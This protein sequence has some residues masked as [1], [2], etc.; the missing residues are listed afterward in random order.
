M[1]LCHQGIIP[2]SC[3]NH[4]KESHEEIQCG[5]WNDTNIFVG[6]TELI[7]YFLN[8]NYADNTNI[9]IWHTDLTHGF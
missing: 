1:C 9:F 2:S 6:H 5:L 7:L 3:Y 4:V 8:T